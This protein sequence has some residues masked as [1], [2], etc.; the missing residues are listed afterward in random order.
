MSRERR[1]GADQ[2]C[3]F[4]PVEDGHANVHHDDVREDAP[5]EVDG[6]AA[7]AGFAGDLHLLFGGDQCGEAGA[8]GGLVVGDENADHALR[9]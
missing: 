2:P 6:F 3:R 8:D 7:V 5:G 9:R 4:D 1:V